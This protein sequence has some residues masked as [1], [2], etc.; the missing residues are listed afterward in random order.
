M[1]D[2]PVMVFIHGWG[3]HSGVWQPLLDQ[4]ES[5]YQC[6]CIDMPGYGSR[7]AETSPDDL[8]ELAD[9]LLQQA[10]D[11]AHWCAWS[12]GGMAAL[13][14]AT[15]QQQRFQSLTLLCSTPR[16]VKD[17]DWP[18]GMPLKIFTN[19][20]NELETDYHSGIKKFLL[21]QAGSGTLAR[22]AVT[23]T[24]AL[25]RQYPEPSS[26]TLRAGLNI[27]HNSDLRGQISELKVPCRVLSGRRDR[28]VHPGIGHDLSKMLGDVEHIELNSGHAPHLSHTSE[29]ADILQK[30][31]NNPKEAIR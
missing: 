9:D 21:L 7:A 26:A 24:T 27:L 28:I 15:R 6:I 23:K 18:Q 17:K 8:N 10:P 30:P 25:L 13:E 14:A 29:L 4:M 20:V 5:R 12:L 16:F 19:F 1:A 22:D 2:K 3:L 31:V 11:A